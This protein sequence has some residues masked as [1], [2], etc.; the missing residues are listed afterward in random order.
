M[1]PV[2]KKPKKRAAKKTA[3]RK[4]APRKKAAK[5]RP[6]PKLISQYAYAKLK[7]V[8]KQRIHDLVKLGKITL[9]KG[10][11]DPDLADKQWAAIHDPRWHDQSKA[12]VDEDEKPKGGEGE[13]RGD[14]LRRLDIAKANLEE[15]K[16]AQLRGELVNALAV[17][18][19]LFQLGATVRDA[20][21]RIPKRIAPDL[22]AETD[23]HKV[24]MMLEDEIMLAL[25]KLVETEM[26]KA[27]GMVA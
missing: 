7:K 19:T 17:K 4:R 1:P 26:D 27:L 2:T 3:A 9:V 16:E 12:G 10:K 25:S 8:S 23:N 14:A 15:M 6:A 18:T 13:S 22:A 20:L 11:I 5:K 21:M 24:R